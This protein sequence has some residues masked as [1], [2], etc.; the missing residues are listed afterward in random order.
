VRVDS[1]NE[2]AAI[3]TRLFQISGEDALDIDRK[4]RDMWQGKLKGSQFY[5]ER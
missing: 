1:K 5:S 3:V 2:I 4:N